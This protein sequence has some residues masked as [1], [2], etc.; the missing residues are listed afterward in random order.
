MRDVL[1]AFGRL[2]DRVEQSPALRETLEQLEGIDRVL[3]VGVDDVGDPRL[4]L[5][6]SSDPVVRAAP[7]KSSNLVDDAA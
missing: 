4:L 6:Y 3:K 7:W 2:R 5:P 1:G